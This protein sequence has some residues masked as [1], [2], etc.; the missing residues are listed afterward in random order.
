MRADP[1][2]RCAI[3]GF[4]STVSGSLASGRSSAWTWLMAVSL[5]LVTIQLLSSIGSGLK[6]PSQSSFR[7]C[8]RNRRPPW[9]SLPPPSRR[10]VPGHA[11]TRPTGSTLHQSCRLRIVRHL[12]GLASLAGPEKG[13][14][15]RRAARRL[16]C[17]S[18]GAGPAKP[19]RL[20]GPEGSWLPCAA[21]LG[22]HEPRRA[23]VVPAVGDLR[24]SDTLRM[25]TAEAR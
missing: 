21:R 1:P 13:S 10:C 2:F 5:A 14:R 17:A 22:C 25:R 15:K 6:S 9:C 16:R 8:A 12:F 24:W 4:I 3:P 7:C 19:V 18:S 11:A 20:S 23:L